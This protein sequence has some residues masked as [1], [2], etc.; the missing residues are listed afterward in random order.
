MTHWLWRL[1]RHRRLDES[2]AARL[3][4]RGAPERLQARVAESER[5]HSG[6]IRICIE[7]GL[8]LADLRRGA[9]ARDRAVAVFADLRVWDTEHRNGV[10]IYLLLAERAIEVVADRGLDRRVDASE[11]QRLLGEMGGAFGE[12]RFEAGLAAAVDA[13]G[14]LLTRHFPVADGQTNIDE[15]PDAPVVR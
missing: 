10:L 9:S 13:V 1:L 6:E 14:A 2:D 15:L 11:W 4:G 3:L 12:A 5:R 8:P 7:A